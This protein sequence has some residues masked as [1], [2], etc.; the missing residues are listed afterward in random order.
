MHKIRAKMLRGLKLR[1]HWSAG[2]GSSS[3]EE[4]LYLVREIQRR[5]ARLVGEIGFNAG[6]SSYALLSASPDVEVVSFDLDVHG[7][8]QVAKKLIDKAFPGRHTLICGDS[9]QT[10][11]QFANDNP[12]VRFDLVF[13]DGGHDYEVAKADI[14][15]MR[16]LSSEHTVLIMDDLIPWQS[17]GVGPFKAWQDAIRDGLLRQNELLQD[18][19]PVDAAEPPGLR[20]W[21]RGQYLFPR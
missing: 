8:V 9:R 11:A 20:V 2:E 3:K 14:A 12:D 13:I 7:T 19:E 16:Q 5:G 18:G 15:N 17:Y 1:G 10:I 4:L 21:A 6:V